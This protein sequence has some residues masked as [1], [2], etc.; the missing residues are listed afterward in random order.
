MKTCYIYIRVSTEEQAKEGFSIDN[1]KRACVDYAKMHGY[2]IKRI[3]S[4]DGKSARTTDRPAFQE[5]F[6]LLKKDPV[7]ALIFYKLDRLFRNVGDF[8]NIRKEMRN[9]GN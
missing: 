1:Q 9:Y 7:D 4:D 8:A 6:T 2:E 5:M 3:F